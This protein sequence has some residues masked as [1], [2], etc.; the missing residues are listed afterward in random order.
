MRQCTCGRSKTYPYCD[1]THKTRADKPAV[2]SFYDEKYADVASKIELSDKTGEV[3]FLKGFMKRSPE[4]K[5]FVGLIDHQYNNPLVS[6]STEHI[7]ENSKTQQF[8]PKLFT[9]YDGKSTNMYS[10]KNLDMH[11]LFVKQ[12][13][14]VIHDWYDMPHLDDFL[15]IFVKKDMQNTV[16]CLIN[17][18]GNESVGNVHSDKQDVVSWT[19]AG[20]I[21]YR[22]Y[23]IDRSLYPKKIE[24]EEASRISYDSYMMEPGDVIYMPRG[25]FHQAIAHSPRASLILDYD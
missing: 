19:C 22:I 14:G 16:K 23:K 9:N 4:W 5:D 13:N 18:A 12:V 25:T 10:I 20:N 2:S 7:Y 24:E 8:G 3:L 21:E 6:E 15:S 11:I 17:F 1:G